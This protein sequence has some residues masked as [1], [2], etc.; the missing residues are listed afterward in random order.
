M[1]QHVRE[2]F[3]HQVGS[4][5]RDASRPAAASAASSPRPTVA[6]LRKLLAQPEGLRQAFI[7]SEILRRPDFFP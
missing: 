7:M 5:T 2:R 3:E 4:L 6:E 1:Q